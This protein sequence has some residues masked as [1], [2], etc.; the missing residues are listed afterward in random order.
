MKQ[1]T[2]DWLFEQL[3]NEKYYI[4]ISLYNILKRAKQI[5]Q[6]KMVEF[7]EDYLDFHCYADFDNQ[8][9]YDK[10][11]IEYFNETYKGDNND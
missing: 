3:E 5:E 1:T 9:T 7:A 10:T 11:A 2:I 8:I 4:S 6:E